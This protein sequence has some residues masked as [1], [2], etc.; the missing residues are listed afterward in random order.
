M[1]I[2]SCLLKILKVVSIFVV[3]III[4]VSIGLLN[5]F[6]NHLRYI[7]PEENTNLIICQKTLS[8]DAGIV[9][10]ATMQWK[11]W[12]YSR[13]RQNGQFWGWGILSCDELH[14]MFPPERFMQTTLNIQAENGNVLLLM[15]S[16]FPGLS[17]S[18]DL[19]QNDSVHFKKHQHYEPL[20]YIGEAF[21]W[22]YTQTKETRILRRI[23]HEDETGSFYIV[24]EN[25]QSF[26]SHCIIYLCWFGK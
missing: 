24:I 6:V 21:P 25:L 15:K 17:P 22:I 26:P 2:I 4:F 14:T 20:Q 3:A 8:K 9:I 12:H 16:L 11:N 10:P 5:D 19:F 23:L 13:S 18:Q 7:P 1:K